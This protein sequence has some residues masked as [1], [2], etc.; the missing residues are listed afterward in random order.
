MHV[1]L[2]SVIVL[3]TQI[4]LPNAWTVEIHCTINLTVLTQ[5]NTSLGKC[6]YGLAQWIFVI[7]GQMYMYLFSGTDLS[8]QEVISQ[9]TFCTHV[10]HYS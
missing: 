5:R 9:E 6:S 7:R 2:N 8:R 3:A 4:P 1:Q 10:R